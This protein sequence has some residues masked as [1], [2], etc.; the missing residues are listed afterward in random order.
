VPLCKEDV[1]VG[2]RLGNA[3]E[4]DLAPIW[5]RAQAVYRSHMSGVYPGICATC[6]EYYTYNF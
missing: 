5:D 6:D 1:R 2:T 3:F 4:E